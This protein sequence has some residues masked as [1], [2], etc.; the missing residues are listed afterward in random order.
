VCYAF[1]DK[2]TKNVVTGFVKN[3]IIPDYKSFL[4]IFANNNILIEPIDI[5]L[6]HEEYFKGLANI[7]SSLSDR[8][9][10]DNFLLILYYLKK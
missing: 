9:E 3:N 7:D 10:D 6:A 8:S 2:E 1:Q 4:P 5:W